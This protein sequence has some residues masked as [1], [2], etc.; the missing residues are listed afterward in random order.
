MLELFDKYNYRLCSNGSTYHH[1]MVP[2]TYKLAPTPVVMTIMRIVIT[3]RYLNS[4]KRVC[5]SLLIETRRIGFLPPFIS[6]LVMACKCIKSAIPFCLR[7]M[8][9]IQRRLLIHLTLYSYRRSDDHGFI[10]V[11]DGCKRESFFSR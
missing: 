8:T 3:I 7:I 1:C 5:L 6:A 11:D 10:K 9:V 4:L 2:V